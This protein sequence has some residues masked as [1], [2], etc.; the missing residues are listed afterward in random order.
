MRQFDPLNE[1]QIKANLNKNHY[2]ISYFKTPEGRG[3]F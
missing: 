3:C 2:K 1:Q